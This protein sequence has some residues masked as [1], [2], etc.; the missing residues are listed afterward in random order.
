MF[1]STP[2]LRCNALSVTLLAVIRLVTAS[3]AELSE[4]S[5]SVIWLVA[6]LVTSWSELGLEPV[7][8]SNSNPTCCCRRCQCTQEWLRRLTVGS[9]W[10]Q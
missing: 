1:R 4:P 6:A 5:L 10:G 7:Q 8:D 3:V 9:R 2:S